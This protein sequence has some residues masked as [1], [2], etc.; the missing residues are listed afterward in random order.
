M[1]LVIDN[2]D[3]FTFNL[4]HYL[5]ELGVDVRVERNDAL[6]VPRSALLQ[7]AGPGRNGRWALLALVVLAAWLVSRGEY[8]GIVCGGILYQVSM[9]LDFS[10]GE[11]ARLGLT[12]SEVGEWLDITADTVVHAWL[13]LAMGVTSARVA[14]G[15]GVVTGAVAAAGVVASAVVAKVSP[16]LVVGDGGTR[17]GRLL[18]G[19]GTR[20][21]YYAMLVL[22]ILLL[23][24]L[25]AA[26]PWLMALVAAGSHAYWL[27]RAAYALRRR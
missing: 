5:I 8:L 14:D 22:F 15:G 23:A 7:D 6:T 18:A 10:D 17:V 27:G 11:V 25:P 26:L 3:S 24:A 19:L 12:E 20:D 2:Y 1:I 13:V 4:V 9:V 21:G 16:T